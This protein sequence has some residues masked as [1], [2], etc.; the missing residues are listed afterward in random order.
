MTGII[1]G[2]ILLILAIIIY[3]VKKNKTNK[4]ETVEKPKTSSTVLPTP[5][6][7]K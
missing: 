7:P 1:I 6:R 2:G 3:R 5:P 4:K